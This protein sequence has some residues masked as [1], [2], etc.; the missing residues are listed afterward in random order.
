MR[1]GAGRELQSP[2]QNR[3]P[4]QPVPIPFYSGCQRPGMPGELKSG[5]GE[6]AGCCDDSEYV[7]GPGLSGHP[8]VY[9]G[10]SLLEFSRLRDSRPGGSSA[11]HGQKLNSHPAAAPWLVPWAPGQRRAD[12]R[13]GG[14]GG[15]HRC[16]APMASQ[17]P[18]VHS[19][20]AFTAARP[21]PRTG[22]GFGG[23]GGG[24]EWEG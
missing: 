14:A 3:C 13:S 5:G 11:R 18:L 23:A 10:K 7:K 2:T 8:E 4:L 12:P 6:R 21:A 16:A 20:D 24:A 19:P 1:G 15:P 22:A 9:L 17:R